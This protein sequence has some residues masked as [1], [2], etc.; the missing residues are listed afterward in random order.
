MPRSVQGQFVLEVGRIELLGALNDDVRH[1]ELLAFLDDDVEP[2]ALGVGLG[3][4]VVDLGV[5][6]AVLAVQ[7]AY[8]AHVVRQDPGVEHRAGL[9]GDGGQQVVG[10]K[11]FR[12]LDADGRNERFFLD[13]YDQA[14]CLRPCLQGRWRCRRNIQV[15]RDS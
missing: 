4:G 2:C 11:L 10:V 15:R 3:Q 5:V 14:L 12:A 9:G 7:F 13:G 6:E 8:L 1:V